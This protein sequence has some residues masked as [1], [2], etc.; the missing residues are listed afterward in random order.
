LEYNG[1]R[2]FCAIYE[3]LAV[4]LHRITVAIPFLVF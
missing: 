2:F 3:G 4:D 1:D